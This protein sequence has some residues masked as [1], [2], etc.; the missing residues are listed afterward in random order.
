M[1]R[2]AE[3]RLAA[4]RVLWVLRSGR[5]GRCAARVAPHGAAGRRAFRRGLGTHVPGVEPR[6]GRAA[7]PEPRPVQQGP[8]DHRAA[9]LSRPGFDG[10][11]AVVAHAPGR[12]RL[13]RRVLD[14]RPSP[15]PRLLPGKAVPRAVIALQRGERGERTERRR[16]RTKTNSY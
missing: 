11:V 10:R 14:L 13:W 3:G 5:R 2:A 7:R 1:A 9:V 12:A 15:R 4:L 16:E 6:L 8:R